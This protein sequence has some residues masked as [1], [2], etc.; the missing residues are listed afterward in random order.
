MRSFE[1]DSL[2]ER[3]CFSGAHFPT[4]SRTPGICFIFK[5][6]TSGRSVRSRS[7]GITYNASPNQG[8][9]GFIRPHP[10]PLRANSPLPLVMLISSC[11]LC[12]SGDIYRTLSANSAAR[13]TLTACVALANSSTC[14]IRNIFAGIASTLT[15]RAAFNV[16]AM[17]I[18]N[19]TMSSSGTFLI[20]SISFI[21]CDILPCTRKHLY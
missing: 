9:S 3:V 5:H 19:A 10:A 18:V 12:C 13:T 15:I 1:D 21:S 6:A 4:V 14:I 16:R 8:L 11:H 17:L 20:R 7:T 2:L